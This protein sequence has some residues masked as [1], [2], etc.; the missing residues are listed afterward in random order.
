MRT[1]RRS[2]WPQWALIAGMFVLT[3]LAWPAAPDR[4]PVHWNLAGE[5]DRYGGKF[6]GLLLLPLLALGS[7]VLL[8]FLPRLDPRQANY[9]AFA[10][11][12]T[13]IRTAILALM[14][15]VQVAVLLWVFG[16]TFDMGI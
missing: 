3:A 4:V 10:A 14:A 16:Y 13:L 8:R 6:E 11:T 1:T 15:L 9:A 7:Y 5:V 12:Y 2:E